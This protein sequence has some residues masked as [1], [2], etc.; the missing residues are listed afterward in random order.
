MFREVLSST[1]RVEILEALANGSLSGREVE[2]RVGFDGS[3]VRRN[4]K[5][6]EDD[7]WL[8]REDGAYVIDSEK[9]FLVDHLLEIS[10]C[11]DAYFSNQDFWEGHD[12][13]PIPSDLKSRLHALSGAEVVKGSTSD[14]RAALEE[15]GQMLKGA[16]W[17]KMLEPVYVPEFVELSKELY[18]VGTSEEI[19]AVPEVHERHASNASGFDGYEDVLRRKVSEGNLEIWLLDDLRIR[20]TVTDEFLSLHLPRE[21]GTFDLNRMLVSRDDEAR[22]WG[23]ELFEH[24]REQGRK[25]DLKTRLGGGE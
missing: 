1:C 4:L 8:R 3:T 16:S 23:V 6:L 21:D 25:A 15:F 12:T 7:G 17:S 13:S 14:P 24:Y 2:E 5:I 9:G 11:F 18:D 10:G 20:L 22:D 19:V